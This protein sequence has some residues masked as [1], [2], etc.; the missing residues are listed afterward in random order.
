MKEL[1][2][3]QWY[4]LSIQRAPDHYAVAAF[5]GGGRYA[6]GATPDFPAALALAR[7]FHT[8][9]PVAIYAVRGKSQSHLCNFD[10]RRPLVMTFLIT[11]PADLKTFLFTR[12]VDDAAA[13]AGLEGTP[14]GTFGNIVGAAEDLKNFGGA[15]LVTMYNALRSDNPITRFDTSANA[16]RRVFEALESANLPV[17]AV[18][19]N[20]AAKE[21][22]KKKAKQKPEP[23]TGDADVVVAH[24]DKEAAVAKKE[25]T[26]RA[27]LER[28]VGKVGDL[29]P[30]RDGSGR[31]DVLK[32]LDG[33]HTAEAIVKQL[34]ITSSALIGYARF[35]GKIGIG[36]SVAENGKV[37][38]V[39]P[40]TKT[41]ADVIVSKEA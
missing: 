35:F 12:Y 11:H 19:A 8:D 24:H 6:K 16:R 41:I 32:L 29:K 5:R 7:S 31:A 27:G 2:E 15:S 23:P 3:L 37:T 17:L 20:A 30:V 18:P 34:K 13:K 1:T 10:P 38:A 25:K 21:P 4:E 28:P 26:T 22:P 33:K 39:Y 14:E 36:I 9:R 40:G